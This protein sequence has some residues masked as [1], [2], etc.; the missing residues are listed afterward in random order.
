MYTGKLCDVVLKPTQQEQNVEQD[1]SKTLKK[2]HVP[3]VLVWKHR[4]A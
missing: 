4:K 1:D 2:C 3:T